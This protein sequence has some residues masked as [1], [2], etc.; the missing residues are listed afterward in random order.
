MNDNIGWSLHWCRLAGWRPPGN[1]QDRKGG[2]GGFGGRIVFPEQVPGHIAW[3][4]LGVLDAGCRGVL[5]V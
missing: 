2:E 1:N 4:F 3:G 5:G